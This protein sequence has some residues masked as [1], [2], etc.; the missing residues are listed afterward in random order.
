[1]T[2]DELLAT[3]IADEA[4]G[5]PHEGKVCVAI[6]LLNRMSLPYQSDGTAVG[7]VLKRN[8]FSGFWFEM[9]DGKYTRVCHTME[10]AQA[11]AEEKFERYSKRSIWADCVLALADA[12]AWADDEPM[13]FTPG[14]AFSGMTGKTVNYL[15]P[16]I[17][18]TAWATPDKLDAKIFHHDFF[19]A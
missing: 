13:S 14:P 3:C 8:Q 10:E 2:D 4:G 1:M 6:V 19:H 12:R 17:S 9:I 16:S 7:T 18:H 15:N 11:R 5:E